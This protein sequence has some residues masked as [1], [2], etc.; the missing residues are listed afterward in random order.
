MNIR[1]DLSY[2]IKD[3][4]EVVFR[5]PV[6]CSQVTGLKVYYT[7]NGVSTSKEFA[8]ADAHGNNVG[9]ID[10]LFAEN[11]VVKVI[12]DVT[13]A[14]AFVQN[15]DTNAYIESTFIKTVNGIAPDENGNVVVQG[16]GGSGEPGA[17]GFSPV[18]TVT[19]TASG[20]V[21]SI[22]DKSGTTTATIVNGKDG[23]DGAQGPQGVQGE[24]GET[25]APGADGAKGDKGDKGD[26]GEPGKDGANGKDGVSATH[27]WNGTTLTVTSASG[28]SSAN[29]KGEKGDKGDQGIQGIQGIQGEKGD[30][31]AAGSNGTNGKDGTSVTVKS[32]SESTADGG[33]NV[34]TFSDGKTVTIKNGSKGS[35]GSS[36]VSV[37]SVKQTTTSTA[38]G[39]NNVVTVTLSNGA[40]STFTVKNG[41]KGSTGA[42]GKDGADGKDG[43]DAES[44]YTDFSLFEEWGIVG[45]SY[46]SGHIV[47]D[48]VVGK[49][50]AVSWGQILA[51]KCGN[52]C[53]AFADSGLTTKTWLTS[54]YGLSLLKA[55][56]RQ[57]LYVLALGINDANVSVAYI[58]T[59]ADIATHADTF[60]GNYARI[61][62]EIQAYAPKAKLVIA[63]IASQ[64]KNYPLANEA[65]VNI[66]EHFGIPLITQADDPYFQSEFYLANKIGGHPN[67]ISYAGM[68][69]A[70][71][72]MIEKAIVENYAYFA[73][74]IGWK[75]DGTATYTNLVPT[76]TDS[77][78][79]IFNGTGYQ[80]GYRLSSS[81]STSACTEQT[82][83]GFIP[84]TSKDVFRLAGVE[85]VGFNYNGS[86]VNSYVGF[87]DANFNCVEML[88]NGGT[89]NSKITTDAA[90]I[91][92][93]ANGVTTFDLDFVAG[94]EFA[95]IRISAK[96]SGASM[97]VTKNEE[98]V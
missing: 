3:G 55:T 9:D 30:T 52:T 81:G 67:A 45:D 59:E 35:T 66:A 95:Y 48:G 6:D 7:E 28:T 78:G 16:G 96:G 21:I 42:A 89:K 31:G 75:D 73:D 49:H 29:L 92:A 40:T 12:L 88:N 68:A 24:K 80:D 54:E 76:S 23:K 17:D 19:Q 43:K 86:W 13:H 93:D 84:C 1:V 83:T 44:Q 72:R 91:T 26:T 25:G 87:Y 20:A 90:S 38:D 69:A 11:V 39:G 15:A 97:I 57:Q 4:T 79:N 85:W 36:G 77:S 32:V 27:S 53:V 37:S 71:K 47:L 98:I 46:A 51:R 62:E 34:V 60:Y 82:A 33:S 74:Y 41:S 14:M 64:E 5:S 65:I 8:F 63:T 56:P 70:F 2:T 61:I 18:A 50:R 10:H 94:F 58:G 22:T